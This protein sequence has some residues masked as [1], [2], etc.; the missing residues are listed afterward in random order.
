MKQKKRQVSWGVAA[1]AVPE[2]CHILFFYDSH[3]EKKRTM[4]RFLQQGQEEDEKVPYLVNDV[5]PDEMRKELCELGVDASGARGAG[6]MS[7]AAEEGRAK[8]E[9]LLADEA[10]LNEILVENPLTTICQYDVRRFS[11][12]V[13]IDLLC[14]HPMAIV[15]GQLV[16]NG[17]YV[18]AR[19]FLHT[20][21]TRPNA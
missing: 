20:L 4:A 10:R 12:Q 14:V 2:G 19:E 18:P 16:K 6:E 7:W 11:G 3:G 9:E 17:Y 5:S 8:M 1:D 13:I 21:E 15:R